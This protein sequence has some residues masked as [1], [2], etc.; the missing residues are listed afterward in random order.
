MIFL[1]N[2]FELYTAILRNT[3]TK[4]ILKNGIQKRHLKMLKKIHIAEALISEESAPLNIKKFSSEIL[5][6]VHIKKAENNTFF[7]FQTDVTGNFIINKK[8]FLSLV[9]FLSRNSTF[10][11]IKSFKNGIYIKCDIFNLSKDLKLLIKKLDAT[12]FYDRKRD[13]LSI[14]F[15]P[16]A[17]SKKSYITQK[18]RDIL[19]GPLSVI[20]YYL[21]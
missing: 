15:F 17:T 7:K 18:D 20:N 12:Y 21:G 13:I 1:T 8:A 6:K 5:T 3:I 4:L 9:L 2:K 10:L 19:N 16:T 11:N 14:L